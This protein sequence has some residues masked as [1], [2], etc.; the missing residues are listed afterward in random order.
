MQSDL[1]A[2]LDIFTYI[3]GIFPIYLHK[4]NKEYQRKDAVLWD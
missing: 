4:K 2:V 3:L 1:A